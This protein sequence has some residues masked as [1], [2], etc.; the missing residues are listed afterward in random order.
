MATLFQQYAFNAAR[1][2]L[3]EDASALPPG[4]PSA[5]PVRMIAYY[6]P[7][8][9][10]IGENDAW[11][12]AGFTEWTNVTRALPR[13]VG[14]RQPRTPAD[15]GF[16]DLRDPDVLRRQADLAR[17]AGVHGFCIHDYWFSGRKV[18]ETP[19]ELLLANPDIDLPFC[20]NWANE[21][22]SRRW[23]GSDQDILLRQLYAPED[24]EGYV[25][26]ILPAL[27]DPR[28][29]RVRGRPL[30]M[31][32]R[33]R[34]LPDVRR[35]LE[36]WRSFLI[37]EG[38]GDPFL[39]MPQSFGDGDP[40]VFGFD[41][42]AGFP[43]HNAGWELPDERSRMDLLDLDFTG[44]ASSYAALAQR[45]L[46]NWTDAFRLFPG[47]CPEWDNEARKPGRGA[48]FYGAS[49]RAYGAWLEAAARQAMTADEPDE[50]IV[51]INAWNEWAE[52]AHL[53][54]DRHYGHA[55]LAETRRVLDKLSGAVQACPIPPAS[56]TTPLM[57][58]PPRLRRRLT[59]R[60]RR[61]ALRALWRRGAS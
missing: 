4:P 19:L 33:P 9:H 32:Y 23:D 30:L 12:G 31:L 2:P 5:A 6:L 35:W 47:V 7:Q 24:A 60:L 14:H 11:W 50:R 41:A 54:P 25:R 39:V 49:P 55:F 42:A 8:F 34:L 29:I 18:L 16:Y 22:W 48:G 28:Y 27:R 61:L 37:A 36:I 45:S 40:R 13:Y 15:L 26:S 38:V 20:L 57:H 43:P 46:Q 51:F 21:N 17:R 59:N 53:E 1:G 3:H 10:A 52:G 44:R 58:T 56:A